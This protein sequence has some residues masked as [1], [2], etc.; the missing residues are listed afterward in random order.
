MPRSK[1]SSSDPFAAREAMMYDKP[2]P[3]REFILEHLKGRAGPASHELLCAELGLTDDESVDALRR[4]LR[5]MQR[6]GQLMQNRR[7]AFGLIDKMNLMKGRVQGMKDGYGFFIPEGGGEDLYI[8]SRQMSKVLDG[9]R[10]LIRPSEH[11]HRGKK[12]AV[13]VEVLERAYTHLVGRYFDESGVGFVVPGSFTSTW[14]WNTCT[15]S[16]RISAAAT[17]ATSD[18]MITSVNSGIRC[19]LQ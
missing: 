9:D 17:L 6:D 5:A 14:S 11:E 15:V 12:E 8:S 7:G 2:I 1:K 3:S 19:Q 13:I 10:V 4:R 18:F 16:E